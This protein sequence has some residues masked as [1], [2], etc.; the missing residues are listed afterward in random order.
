MSAQL[1]T[2]ICDA[3][4][5][6]IRQP[7]GLEFRNYGDQ[8]SYNKEKRTIELDKRDA[9]I[10]LASVRGND[11]V[12]AA[13]L[14]EASKHA[15]SGRLTIGVDKYENP[16]NEDDASP[17]PCKVCGNAFE[18]HTPISH[19]C[20]G[21]ERVTLSY[22]TGQYWPTEYRKAVAAVCANALWMHMRERMPEP[23]R[24]PEGVPE[25]SDGPLYDGL[26]AGAWLRKHFR[27][28]F[29]SRMQKRWF[30]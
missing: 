7:P 4:A 22:C 17:K 6:F 13:A 27:R 16:E 18:T 14:L 23:S 8:V 30:D 9:E 20:P 26:S 11:A 12:T 2:L 1:K 24:A 15:F 19:E 25:W 29:G 28:E 10:L 5:A 21:P 3:L